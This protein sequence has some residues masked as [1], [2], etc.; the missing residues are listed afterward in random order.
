LIDSADKSASCHECGG[1]SD[2]GRPYALEQILQFFE[3]AW[4]III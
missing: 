4:Q 1:G 2:A 3:I